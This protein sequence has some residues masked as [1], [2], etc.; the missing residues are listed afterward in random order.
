MGEYRKE[1]VDAVL[2]IGDKNGTIIDHK[3][4]SIPWFCIE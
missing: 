2:S 3:L 1:K 4:A